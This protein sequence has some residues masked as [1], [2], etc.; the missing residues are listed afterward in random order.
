MSFSDD[1]IISAVKFSCFN[2]D[3][4]LFFTP[5]SFEKALS[6]EQF[7]VGIFW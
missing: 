3:L 6:A 1:N 5:A 7:E 2:V 4:Y